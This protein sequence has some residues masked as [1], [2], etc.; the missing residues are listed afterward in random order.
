MESE[1]LLACIQR[2]LTIPRAPDFVI[3]GD[4]G[5]IYLRRWWIIPRNRFF[6][7]YLHH[8]LQDDDGRAEHDHPWHSCSII[9]RGGYIEVIKNVRHPRVAGTVRFRRATEA[10]RL[11]LRKNQWRW[12]GLFKRRLVFFETMPCWTL[13]ITGPRIREWGFHCPQG[14]RHWR[15]FTAKDDSGATGAGCG[16]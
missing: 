15:Q 6:N 2:T 4:D 11:V 10:H 13:F 5:G 16:E 1:S 7:I 3:R 12:V 9:L 14:W 8:I